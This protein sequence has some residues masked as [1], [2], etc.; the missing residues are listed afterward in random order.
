M[1]GDLDGGEVG[2]GI[3]EELELE[4]EVTVAKD[5]NPLSSSFEIGEYK[6]GRKQE[7]DPVLQS[8]SRL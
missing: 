4:S 5:S 3:L 1:S 6:D 2:R 8:L 7:G